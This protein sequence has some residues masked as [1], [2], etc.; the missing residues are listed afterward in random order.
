MAG[1]RFTIALS[2][3][4]AS[5]HFARDV[6]PMIAGLV[7]ASLPI[8]GKLRHLRWGGEAGYIL[9]P[10]LAKPDLPLA[11]PISFYPRGALI[12]RPEHGEIALSYGEAQARDLTQFAGYACIL[13][14]VDQGDE[15]M[16]LLD[17]VR[18]TREQGETDA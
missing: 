11:Q 18:D 6:E 1:R 7:S 10:A 4:R 12:Y 17:R 16:A 15:G 9:V 13:G 14:W 3:V 8:E 2:G 5:G